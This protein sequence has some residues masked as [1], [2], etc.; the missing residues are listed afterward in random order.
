MQISVSS[1]F[2][3]IAQFPT[4]CAFLKT[5]SFSQAVNY[6]IQ[7]HSFPTAVFVHVSYLGVLQKRN[8]E[9]G[10]YDTHCALT[11]LSTTIE[12]NIY[13]LCTQ[14]KQCAHNNGTLQH[15]IF[16]DQ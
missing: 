7:F 15:T 3:A 6:H 2:L 5:F 14:C 1:N 13:P 12:N 16:F 4:C 10:Q 9:G 8:W 11:L